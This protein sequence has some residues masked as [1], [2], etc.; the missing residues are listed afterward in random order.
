MTTSPSHEMSLF[1]HSPSADERTQESST[2]VGH[3]PRVWIISSELS[4]HCG[5]P[6]GPVHTHAPEREVSPH[7]TSRSR[8]QER[9]Q[10]PPSQSSPGA[11]ALLGPLSC[12]SSDCL[13]RVFKLAKP[14][15]G[16]WRVVGR[17]E[18]WRVQVLRPGFV[19][20]L[21]HTLAHLG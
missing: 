15:A 7:H 10:L 2:K 19:S 9:S 3:E 21:S 1:L 8:R 17:E 14:G 6:P 18:E 12:L 4:P 20:R 13:S 11:S 5:S 16:V